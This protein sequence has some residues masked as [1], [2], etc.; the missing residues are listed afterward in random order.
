MAGAPGSELELF[1]SLIDATRLLM[2]IVDAQGEV[3]R[4][5]R[6]VEEVTGL[7]A[8]AFRGPIWRLAALPDE[9]LLLKEH[10]APLNEE[11]FRTGFCSTSRLP[12]IGTASS[13]GR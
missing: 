7:A 5:N 8:E 2:L 6:A 13:T 11:H 4:V 3:V 12:A 10:F 1:R 9:R